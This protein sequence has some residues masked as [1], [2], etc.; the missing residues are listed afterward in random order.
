MITAM[1]KEAYNPT[2]GLTPAMI[3]KA[4]ASGIKA[5][6]TTI[7]A[8]TSA[9]KFENHSCLILLYNVLSPFCV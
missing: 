1:Q 8:R 6:A 9:G 4:M 5:K 2:M 7:P 3:E